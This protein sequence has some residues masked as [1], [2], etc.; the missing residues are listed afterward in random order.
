MTQRKKFGPLKKPTKT[1]LNKLTE[2]PGVYSLNDDN[3]KILYIGK[4]KRNRPDERIKEHQDAEKVLFSKFGFIKTPTQEDAL[5]L[6][7]KLIKK[8]KPKYNKQGK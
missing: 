2:G 7:K 8:R 1:N 3:G 4:A 6:E 5:K